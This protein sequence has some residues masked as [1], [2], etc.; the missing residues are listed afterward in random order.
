MTSQR[1]LARRT[2]I[3]LVPLP[4]EAV[5][6]RPPPL[7]SCRNRLFRGRWDAPHQIPLVVAGPLESVGK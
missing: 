2:R 1:P 6:F 4:A 3:Q 5:I 7:G